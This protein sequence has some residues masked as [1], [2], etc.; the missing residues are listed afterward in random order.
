[1]LMQWYVS[2]HFRIFATL[3]DFPPGPR[4]S[5]AVTNSKAERLEEHRAT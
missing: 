2:Y 1:M 5:I 4:D 3:T